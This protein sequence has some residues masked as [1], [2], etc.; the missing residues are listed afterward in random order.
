MM[1]P[2]AW[3]VLPGVYLLGGVSPGYL[4]VRRRTGE[5]VRAQGSGATGATNA[6][7]ILGRKGF[8]LVM[9]LDA[10]KG[11]IAALVARLVGLDHG[12]EFAAA[13]AVVAGHVWPVQLAFRGGRGLSPLLGAWLVL[14]P[15]AIGI[16]L[17]VAGVAWAISRRRIPSGLFGALLLPATTWWE[18]HQVAAAVFAGL[19][20][21]IVA[22]AHRAH[23]HASAAPPGTA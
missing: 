8:I 6:A 5:D 20:F 14:A 18:T 4:L 22:I 9:V 10:I 15:L 3:L 12:W 7:R 17:L 1:S 13:A 23:L 11:A 19:T 16:C 21:C 2:A